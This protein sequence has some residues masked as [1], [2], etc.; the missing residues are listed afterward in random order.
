MAIDF[1]IITNIG[2]DLGT[3]GS[4]LAAIAGFAAVAYAGAF[5]YNRTKRYNYVVRIFNRDAIGNV[6]Q[7]PDD[8]A[9]IFLDKKTQYRLF[10]LRRNK[11]GLDP[12]E[13]PYILSSKGKKIVYLLQT[14]LKNYQFMKPDISKAPELIF[15]VQD[16][17]V[18]WALNAYERNKKPFGNKFLEQ[19]MPF[20]GMAFVFTLVVVALFFIFKHI[21]V[22]T[23]VANAFRDAAIEFAKVQTGTAVVD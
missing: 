3:W 16:E 21:G 4:R 14:G 1:S 5:A 13:I 12:D 6:I 18:A 19:I 9:G 22:L 8:K 23:E 15:N 20:I 17:D 7:L 11:F 10:L 2:G